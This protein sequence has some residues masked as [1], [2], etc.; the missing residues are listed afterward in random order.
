MCVRRYDENKR[1]SLCLTQLLHFLTIMDHQQM[2]VEGGRGGGD[3]HWYRP[4]PNPHRDHK[5][6]ENEGEEEE[7]YISSTL[8]VLSVSDAWRTRTKNLLC[9]FI[10]WMCV[11]VCLCTVRR[12]WELLFGLARRA[13]LF[14]LITNPITWNWPVAV[15]D[16]SLGPLLPP[17]PASTMEVT[18]RLTAKG[19]LSFTPPSSC[20]KGLH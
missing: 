8:T 18:R 2:A 4:H 5:E 10:T 12:A 17:S 13:F 16:K 1:L 11:C 15:G 6:E 19:N 7:I 9:I 3:C 14:F 20:N